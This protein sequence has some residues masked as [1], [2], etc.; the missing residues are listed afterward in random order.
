[1]GCGCGKEKVVPAAIEDPI[2]HPAAIPQI[3]SPIIKPSAS[4]VLI[5]EQVS[6]FSF[7]EYNPNLFWISFVNS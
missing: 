4:E 1:M 7:N 6:Y 3:H 2:A 5:S